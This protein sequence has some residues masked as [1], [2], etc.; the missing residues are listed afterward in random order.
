MGV[1]SRDVVE[2]YCPHAPE[3]RHCARGVSPTTE[4]S[5]VPGNFVTTSGSGLD[6]DI[7]LANATYR[8]DRMT[9]A[10]AKDTKRSPA[11]LRAEITSLLNQQASAPFGGPVGEPLIN[12][13]KVNLELR[14]MY[15][16]PA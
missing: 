1:G 6:P 2:R 12:G 16:A 13:L 11:A 5:R 9:A 3:D 10:W 4:R 8:L 7:T 14:K 15:G